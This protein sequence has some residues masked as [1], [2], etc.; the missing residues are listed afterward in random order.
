MNHAPWL[1]LG[2]L[3]ATACGDNHQVNPRTLFL[4]PDGSE[5]R[6]RLIEQEPAPF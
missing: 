6:L 3:F 4:A 5:I 1:L 2:T